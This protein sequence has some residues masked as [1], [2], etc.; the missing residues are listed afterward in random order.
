MS[1]LAEQM[2][3]VIA[4]KE[5]IGELVEGTAAKA[6]RLGARSATSAERKSL[7][8]L[9]DAAMKAQERF[10]RST[11]RALADQNWQVA[12]P[13]EMLELREIAIREGE[14]AKLEFERYGDALDELLTAV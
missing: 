5:A 14:Q 6:A 3:R 10:Y 7:E 4:L 12:D 8:H 13:A 11:E 1:S 9:R 2:G